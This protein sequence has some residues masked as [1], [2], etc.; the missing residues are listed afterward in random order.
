MQ[1]LIDLHIPFYLEVERV[2]TLP[3]LLEELAHLGA[4]LG[5]GEGVCVCARACALWWSSEFSIVVG[6][7]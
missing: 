4:K 2:C 5:V 7:K 3:D 1:L 6:G